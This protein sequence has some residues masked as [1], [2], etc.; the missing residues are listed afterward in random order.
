MSLVG[1][2]SNSSLRSNG[3]ESSSTTELEE[4]DSVDY[5]VQV[6]R[7]AGAYDLSASTTTL[8]SSDIGNE[9][10]REALGEALLMGEQGIGLGLGIDLNSADEEVEFYAGEALEG[11]GGHPPSGVDQVGEVE[12]SESDSDI[13]L[14]TPLP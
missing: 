3:R 14:H 7:R 2:I 9:T 10:E 5:G 8:P 1:G 11:F 13:D 6:G 12:E 4:G